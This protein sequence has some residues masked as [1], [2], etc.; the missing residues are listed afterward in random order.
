MIQGSANAYVSMLN[1]AFFPFFLFQQGLMVATQVALGS[2]RT[3]TAVAQRGTQASGQ[4]DRW[5]AEA[6]EGTVQSD[7]QIALQS[8]GASTGKS[9]QESIEA[10]SDRPAGRA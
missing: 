1:S 5:S 9:A 8:R 6:A 2:L 7:V 3:T 10:G 4:P